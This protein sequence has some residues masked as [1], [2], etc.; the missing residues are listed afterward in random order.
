MSDS[1]AIGKVK[2]ANDR[3]AAKYPLHAGIL[4]RWQLEE[5]TITSTMGVG[6]DATTNRLR[7][8]MDPKFVET[9]SLDLLVG[10]LHHELNHVLF[11]HVHRIPEPDEDV[12]AM[13]IAQEVTV[14]EWVPEPL[15]DG[16]LLLSGYPFLKPNEDTETRYKQLRSR[17]EHGS[18]ITLPFEA[19]KND[20]GQAG[21]ESP[22]AVSQQGAGNEK[23]GKQKD[24]SPRGSG[25]SDADSPKA[26]SQ[27][28]AVNE[29]GGAQNKGTQKGLD[30]AGGN[31]QN[32]AAK[33]SGWVDNH[34]T[35][36]EIQGNAEAS[37]AVS[38]YDIDCV[39]AALLNAQRSQVSD[40]IKVIIDKQW[41]VDD[42]D[43]EMGASDLNVGKAKVPWQ[44]V[45]RQYVGHATIR[46]T[47]FGRPPRRFP[48]LVGIIPGKASR[49]PWPR[50]LAAIDTSPSLTDEMLADI[51][52]ELMRMSRHYPVTVVECDLM[53]RAVYP[54][55]K[56]IRKV[57]GRC[58][59]D[60]RPPF[61]PEFLRS[62]KA[63]VV[64]YF[65]DGDGPAPEKAPR[66]PVIWCLTKGGANKAGWGREVWMMD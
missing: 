8:Y 22:K 14:N 26:A 49:R 36:G 55:T 48:H 1:V 6:F 30:E 11:G 7:L 17:F 40:K 59:T 9:S 38:D 20:E 23:G 42:L 32:G 64:V 13:T 60:L 25:K 12:R 65:T 63:D 47:A 45:L 37:K 31:D 44:T 50:V 4:G 27:Q 16:A 15:P 62:Q 3:M 24:G 56:P 61:D 57:H 33:G 19:G 51:S 53:I 34:G 58:G 35:W 41:N 43:S 28:G 52:A 39:W 21:A 54:Y 66:V 2:L 18:G 10:V 46:G 29:K 5:S